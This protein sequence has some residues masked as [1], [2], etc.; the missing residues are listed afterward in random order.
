MHDQ[1]ERHVLPHLKYFKSAIPYEWLK[2][3][4]LAQH[5]IAVQ[6]EVMN[7]RDRQA[8]LLTQNFAIMEIRQ[9]FESRFQ[10]FQ[11]HVAPNMQQ[12]WDEEIME[13]VYQAL[14]YRKVQLEK[15]VGF[16]SKVIEDHQTYSNFT[17]FNQANNIRKLTVL[18]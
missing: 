13:F 9:S 5:L 18:L 7:L 6:D 3:D 10:K 1:L 2:I 14:E 16:V 15:S 17:S 8:T 11:Q 12:K 4:L